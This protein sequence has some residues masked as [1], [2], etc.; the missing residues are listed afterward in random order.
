MP[1]SQEL[2]IVGFHKG[3]RMQIVKLFICKLE[4]AEMI[5]LGIYLVDHFGREDY[6]F[7]TA[8]ENINTVKVGVFME[9]HHVHIELVKI[10]VQE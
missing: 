8:F 1:E 6:A 4:R 10:R 3:Y 2:D 9:H 7:V 5:D